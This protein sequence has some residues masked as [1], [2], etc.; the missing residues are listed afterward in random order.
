VYT[1]KTLVSTQFTKEGFS[2]IWH[3]ASLRD[4][5]QIVSQKK[6]QMHRPLQGTKITKTQE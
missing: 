1:D 5:V 2:S 4:Q 6:E 3:S